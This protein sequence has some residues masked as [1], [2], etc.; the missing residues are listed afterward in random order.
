MQQPFHGRSRIA[1]LQLIALGLLSLFFSLGVNAEVYRCVVDGKTQYSDEPCGASAEVVDVSEA[2]K[3]TGANLQNPDLKAMGETLSDDRRQ[4][5]LQKAIADQHKKIERLSKNYDRTRTRLQDQLDNLENKSQYRNWRTNEDR[6]KKYKEK[7]RE[8]R[9][10][11]KS[12]ER[13]YKGDK[14]AAYLKLR[15][16]EREERRLEREIRRKNR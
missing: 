3:P 7:R 2:Q 4:R 15:Q 9:N 1:V 5:E 12:V 14:E 6:R 16:L 10:E 11:K 13:R 8:L